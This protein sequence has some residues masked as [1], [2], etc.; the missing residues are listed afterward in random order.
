MDNKTTLPLDI[1]TFGFVQREDVDGKPLLNQCGRDFLYYALNYFY[2][3]KFNPQIQNP[4]QIRERGIFGLKNFPAI[5]VWTGLTFYKVPKLLTSL[6]L[7]F[8]M[9]GKRVNNYL[10]FLFALLPFHSL[11]Y[12]VSM[13]M[14]EEG[15]RQGKA[16]GIDIA[17]S[18]GGL[19]DHVMFVYGYDQDSIYV[20]DT[21]KISGLNYTKITP[22]GDKRFIMELPKSEIQKRWTVFGR[23]WIVSKT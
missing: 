11:K 23:I 18:L 21:H 1:N 12:E 19:V 7:K 14:I 20:I 10:Q 6:G 9:N 22:E 15:I 8:S 17:I 13:D 3:E 16:V 2:P 5:L 4:V